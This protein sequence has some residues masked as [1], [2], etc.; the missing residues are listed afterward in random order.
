MPKLLTLIFVLI[1]IFRPAAVKSSFTISAEVENTSA[2]NVE[3]K[4]IRSYLEN[5]EIYPKCFPD[6][7][8]VKQTGTNESEWIYR[9]VSPLAEPWN[10]S[11]DQIILDTPDTLLIFE[12]KNPGPDYLYCKAS[13]SSLPE[14]R[15]SLDINIKVKIIRENAG[16]I[17]WLAGILGEKFISEKMKDKLDDDLLK[18]IE[19]ICKDLYKNKK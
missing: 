15:T 4:T 3:M 8:S 18:F 14:G 17:H 1:C 6:M 12:S 2:V 9:V 7:I 19:N 13:L 11:F 5:L 16:D 10:V